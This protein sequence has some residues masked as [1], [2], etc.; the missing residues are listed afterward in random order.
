MKHSFLLLLLLSFINL[1]GNRVTAQCTPGS[2]APGFRCVQVF[3][4]TDAYTVI[5][6]TSYEISVNGAP[7]ASGSTISPISTTGVVLYSGCWPDG[8]VITLTLKDKYGDGIIGSG[9]NYFQIDGTVVQTNNFTGYGPTTYTLNVAAP[10]PP[11][12]NDNPCNAIQLTV[13]PAICIPSTP[14]AWSNATATSGVP[15]PGCASYNTGD[16][17][18][19]AVVPANGN[20]LISTAAGSITN[21]GLAA[22]RGSC[23]T[24]TLISCDDDSGPGTMPQLVLTG[25]TPGATIYIRFWDYN[26]AVTG[27]IG[28]ICASTFTAPAND[29][30]CGALAIPVVSGACTPA[31]PQVWIG[32]TASANVPAP[33]C[34]SYTTGDVWFSAVVPANGNLIINTL[35]GATTDGGMA[36]Y[37][38]T[39]TNLTLISCDD[40]NGPGSMPFLSLTGL[41]PGATIY[42]RFWDYSDAVNGGIGGICAGDSDGNDNICFPSDVTNSGGFSANNANATPDPTAVN[43]AI[44]A[45]G[46]GWSFENTLWY[47]FNA[48]AL[49]TPNGTLTVAGSGTCGTADLQAALLVFTGTCT[50]P[51]FTRIVSGDCVNPVVLNYTGLTPNSQYYLLIDGCAGAICNFTVSGLVLPTNALDLSGYY[52]NF[53]NKVFWKFDN[54]SNAVK[55]DLEKSSNGA[56][57]SFVTSLPAAASNTGHLYFYND[58]APFTGNN[59]Y[60]IKVTTASGRITYSE[61]INIPNKM[62][63]QGMDINFIQPNPAKESAIIG[64]FSEIQASVQLTVTD[65]AGRK[66]MESKET[67]AKGLNRIKINTGAISAGVYFIKVYDAKNNS[68]IIKRLIKE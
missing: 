12:A 58:Q 14:F 4:N 63:Q 39:C 37:R 61:I 15:V 40:N 33:G 55:F 30:P 36:A 1:T 8:T 64:V 6:S 27:S 51:S 19:T 29:D 45:S 48:D 47:K 56:D 5:D 25:L 46:I 18:F 49:G 24:L 31:N 3:V 26:D 41:T 54:S 66:V 35:A 50:A 11:P 7:V 38:G 13:E 22:Y 43:T 34:A 59:F 65:A 44:T 20:L 10:P 32:A 67:V 16:I 21:G 57:F 53:T 28:G 60:R 42:I 9:D 23:S 52:Q 2:C 62:K 17:W 68:T